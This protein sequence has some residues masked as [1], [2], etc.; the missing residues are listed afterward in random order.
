MFLENAPGCADSC[1]SV[2]VTTGT[3]RATV[4]QQ[5]HIRVDYPFD[6]QTGVGTWALN[7]YEYVKPDEADHRVNKIAKALLRFT[8]GALRRRWPTYYACFTRLVFRS[9]CERV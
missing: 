3:Q 4:D 2:P 9:S 6:S 8:R 5:H 1:A 7:Y